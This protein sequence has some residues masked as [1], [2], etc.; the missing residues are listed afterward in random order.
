MVTRKRLVSVIGAGQGDAALLEMA[1]ETG[2]LLARRGF[3]VV[4]GGLGGVMEAASEGAAAAGGETIGLLPGTR[5]ESANEHVHVAIATGI[6]DA[7]NAI[8]A[9]AG[10]GAIAIG[11]EAGTL[12]EIGLALKR[13]LPVV[14]L[15]S[16]QLESEQLR[17]DR[18]FRCATTPEEAV[19]TLLR[20]VEE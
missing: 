11:G 8:V 2:R 16:W 12:S 14:S 17:P 15:G 7:R 1:R 13:G 19:A 10:I 5:P 20:L 3:V 18:R 9:T 6:G 4:T